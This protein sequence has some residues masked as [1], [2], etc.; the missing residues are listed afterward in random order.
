MNCAALVANPSVLPPLSTAPTSS[1]LPHFSPYS[2][3]GAAL[4]VDRGL[5]VLS[6]S[7]SQVLLWWWT[8]G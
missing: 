7:P 5:M 3:S 4:V 2:L 6:L 1:L 8:G